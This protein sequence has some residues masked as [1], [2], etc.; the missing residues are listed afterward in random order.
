MS[1]YIKIVDKV[2]LVLRIF[3]ITM[4]AACLII[5]FAEV[6]ARYVLHFSIGWSNEACRFL[7]I[8]SAYIGAPLAARSGDLINIIAVV[9]LL[10]KKARNAVNIIALIGS[11][12][13]YVLIICGTVLMMNQISGIQ[14]SAALLIPMNRMYGVIAIGCVFLILNTLA[15]FFEKH[16]KNEEPSV[17]LSERGDNGR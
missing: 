13:T 3:V 9:N 5:G 12:A 17:N 14:Y 16:L 8:G 1:L 4:L 10:P 7:M 6:V 15:A 11:I 2:N